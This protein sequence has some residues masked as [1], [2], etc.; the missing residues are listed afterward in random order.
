MKKSS[1][2]VSTLVFLLLSFDAAQAQNKS[3]QNLIEGVEIIPLAVIRIQSGNPSLK[4]AGEDDASAGYE[5]LSQRT[6]VNAIFDLG[7][8]K[9]FKDGA[10]VFLNLEGGANTQKNAGANGISIA[11]WDKL[12]WYTHTEG[13]SEMHIT[14]KFLD[15]KL[16]LRIGKF[17]V[18]TEISVSGS[19]G[20]F[21]SNIFNADEVFLG[22]YGS[23]YGAAV[24]FEPLE[25]IYIG[26]QYQI[27][28]IDNVGWDYAAAEF[29]FKLHIKGNEG[30]YKIAYW[31]DNSLGLTKI[32]DGKR[33]ASSGLVFTIDQNIKEGISFFARY[34]A[35]MSATEGND[36]AIG[37]NGYSI[38]GLGFVVSGSF[39]SRTQ[40]SAGIGFGQ[41]TLTGKAADWRFGSENDKSYKS[42][43]H[44][45]LYYSYKAND[46]I[47]FVPSI[48]FI[49]NP[50]GGSV[51][52]ISDN[53]YIDSI[54]AYSLRL[55]Y[56]F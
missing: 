52:D 7:F 32:D 21:D 42:E 29:G 22:K 46:A 27:N 35:P 49:Q 12:T 3:A 8:Q 11:A 16:S 40:D 55:M 39:W 38:F 54:L 30:A 19:G 56:N 23:Y 4:A 34:G 18:H 36:T 17:W 28:D 5:N 10:V 37:N 53:S 26:G 9:T 25:Y 20:D 1:I 45:E 24:K 50:M 33:G 47:S 14:Q 31:T 2:A 43:T 41:I 13:I 44:F 51:R 48:Q 6:A 15:D